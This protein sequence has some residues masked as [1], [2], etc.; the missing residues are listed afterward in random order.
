MGHYIPKQD[1]NGIDIPYRLQK[2]AYWRENS[3]VF[4][5]FTPKVTC[6]IILFGVVIPSFWFFTSR[7]QGKE[8]GLLIIHSFIHFIYLFDTCRNTKTQLTERKD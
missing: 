4:F 2:A 3:Q 8:G 7:A 1:H 5:K 6:S